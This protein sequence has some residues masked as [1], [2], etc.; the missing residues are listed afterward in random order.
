M[1]ALSQVT[2]MSVAGDFGSAALR[3]VEMLLSRRLAHVIASD[4]HSATWHPPILSAAVEAAAAIMGTYEDA[5]RLVTEIPSVI[6][7]GGIPELPEPG[8]AAN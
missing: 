6:L 7:S 5:K 4:A 8:R 3:C 1:G 2:A